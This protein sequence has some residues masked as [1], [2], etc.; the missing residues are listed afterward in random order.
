MKSIKDVVMTVL[1]CLCLVTSTTAAIKTG[2]IA[3]PQG[4]QGEQGLQGEKGERGEKGDQGIQGEK[5]D[6]GD[7]GIQ[8]IQGIQGEQGLQGIQG[9]QG[10]K[11]D[12]GEQGI[13][14][15]QGATGEQGIQG[16]Q[17][18][19]GDKG[20]SG[21]TPYIGYNN[22][23]WIGDRDTGV[24]AQGQIT[25]STAYYAW[26][27]FEFTVQGL[28][29]WIWN[30]PNLFDYSKI[31][32]GTYN[33]DFE[34]QLSFKSNEVRNG[35]FVEYY[36]LKETYGGSFYIEGKCLNASQVLQKYPNATFNNDLTECY[37]EKTV[38]SNGDWDKCIV[39]GEEYILIS[40]Q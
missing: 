7:Q 25:I 13:Q 2:V 1:L 36:S 15:I 5:G 35:L 18:E 22:N 8:G 16:I 34:G 38:F 37:I 19:K 30:Y 9:I 26:Q 14:G 21:L 20:D 33:C 3:G 6:K 32:F 4:I 31:F 23:W 29:S 40:N 11:G 28:G 24:L 17:G 10:E 39:K 27:P 12:R